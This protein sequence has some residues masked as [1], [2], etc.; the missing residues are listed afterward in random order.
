MLTSRDRIGWKVEM[1]IRLNDDV[2]LVQLNME[3]VNQMDY[4]KWN[5]L[6]GLWTERNKIKL[7]QWSLD[8]K[9]WDGTWTMKCEL[10]EM[11]WNMNNEVTKKASTHQE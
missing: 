9:K 10:T 11:R 7:D 6:D 4:G 2:I 5:E 3:N 8:W 1:T